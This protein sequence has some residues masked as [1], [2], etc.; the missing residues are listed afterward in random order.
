MEVTTI[1]RNG[2][3]ITFPT[4]EN[5]PIK[6]NIPTSVIQPNRPPQRKQIIR[7]PDHLRRNVTQKRPQIN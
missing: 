2:V 4:K 5:A 6:N 7:R 3:F 1:K